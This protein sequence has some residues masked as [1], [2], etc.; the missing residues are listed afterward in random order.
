MAILIY[1]L[2]AITGFSSPLLGYRGGLVLI[3]IVI[4][5]SLLLFVAGV[6]LSYHIRPPKAE[7]R[8]TYGDTGLRL[9]NISER[10]ENTNRDAHKID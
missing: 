7:R 3:P 5:G 2:M 8:L 1:L 9:R 6:S 10:A 4:F